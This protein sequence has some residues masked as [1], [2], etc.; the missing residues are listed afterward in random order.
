MKYDRGQ[1]RVIFLRTELFPYLFLL[2]ALSARKA[3]GRNCSFNS[4]DHYT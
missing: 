2:D 3:G 4:L 1:V